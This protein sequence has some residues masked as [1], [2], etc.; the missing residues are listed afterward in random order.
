MEHD[1]LWKVIITSTGEVW[2]L[3]QSQIR[4]VKNISMGRQAPAEI[5]PRQPGK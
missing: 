1:T 2:D 3:P 5:T 4:G